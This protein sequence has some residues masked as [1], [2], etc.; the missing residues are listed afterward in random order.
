MTR[1]VVIDASAGV[2]IVIGTDRGKDLARLIS[3]SS[4]LWVP[5]HFY[6][7]VLGAIR[8]LHIVSHRVDHRVAERAVD[9]LLRWHL[10]QVSL[11][12]L[13]RPAW[14][15]RFNLTG[16]DALYVA[17]ALRLSGRLL[18]DDLRLANSPGLP[19]DIEFLCLPSD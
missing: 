10:R 5:E 12:S 13:L 3:N 14:N 1:P 7:E 17:L 18:T 19:A 15:Y 4:E 8:H 2:E 6:A 16:A 11:P 9:R